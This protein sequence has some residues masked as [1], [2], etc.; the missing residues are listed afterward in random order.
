MTNFREL[1]K[2]RV[3]QADWAY[4][5]YSWGA[6]TKPGVTPNIKLDEESIKSIASVIKLAK[7]S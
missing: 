5:S 6:T 4:L 3:E 7:K 2:L 1:A